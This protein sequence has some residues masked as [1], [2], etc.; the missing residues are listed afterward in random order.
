M[1]NAITDIFGGIGD[2]FEAQGYQTAAS[3]LNKAATVGTQEEGIEKASGAIQQRATQRQLYMAGGQEVGA[4]GAGGLSTTGS[5]K[6]VIGSSVS[7]GAIQ[8]QLLA[9]QTGIQE[10]GTALQVL[11]TQAEA[12]QAEATSQSQM[13]AGAGGILGGLF[14]L[15]TSPG[16]LNLFSDRRLKRSIQF[17]GTVRG[18]PFYFWRWRWGF[19]WRVGPIAQ[20]VREIYPE[21]VHR[22][23]TGLLK[24][25]MK[26]LMT[27]PN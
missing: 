19:A 14:G 27:C 26:G 16:F 18:V 17:W 9:A 7:Q 11:G 23:W 25:D 22:H 13:A 24:V 20:E 10:E 15:G 8:Q 12:A 5:V 6:S 2:F 1:A 3:L 21:F 4:A